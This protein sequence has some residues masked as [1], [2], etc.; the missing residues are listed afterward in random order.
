[1]DYTSDAHSQQANIMSGFDVTERKAQA[2]RNKNMKTGLTSTNFSLGDAKVDYETTSKA[3][4]R[5]AATGPSKNQAAVSIPAQK[6]SIDFGRETPTYRSV[7]QVLVPVIS[8]CLLA[9]TLTSQEAMAYQ[10]NTTDFQQMRTEVNNLKTHLRRHQISMG[11]EKVAYTTDYR[12][13]FQSNPES[14]YSHSDR[15]IEL[16]KVID[17]TRRCHFSLGDDKTDYV[18]NAHRSLSL[19]LPVLLCP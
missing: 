15:K 18:S 3:G 14:C 2:L 13:K 7:A 6:S 19:S 8:P 11:N 10:G 17:D 1:M 12:E 5:H 4:Q 16:R 9:L